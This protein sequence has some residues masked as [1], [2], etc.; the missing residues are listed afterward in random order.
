MTRPT[1]PRNLA[2]L[3][4][5]VA[6]LAAMLL[7]LGFAGTAAASTAPRTV[8]EQVDVPAGPGQ[9]GTIALDTTLYL[10]ATT[11]A[12]AVLVAHGFG[13]TKASVDADARALVDRGFVVLAWTARG[14]GASG[15]QIALDSPDYEVADARALVDRLAGRPEVLQ[16]GPGDPRVGVTG[17]SYGGALALLLAGYDPRVDALAPMITWNDL[18]QALFPNAAAV[19]GSLPADTPAR[20][21][22]GPD[23]VF[24]RGWA[25]VFFSAGLA[26]GGGPR[27]AVEG[28]TN[29]ADDTVSGTVPT[30]CP[31]TEIGDT[32]VAA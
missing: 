25:G 7:A 9:E 10:P 14:F 6:L 17:G 19:P 21:A 27:G 29:P 1:G 24:K 16:D 13:G 22:F 31:A 3:R 26:P 20:G 5:P 30:T 4:L 11:P 2:V 28:A 12:P 8:E 15:G 32:V 18:G 23:G